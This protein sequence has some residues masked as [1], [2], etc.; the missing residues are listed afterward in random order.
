MESKMSAVPVPYESIKIADE[1]NN[2]DESDGVL[3]RKIY[4]ET[5]ENH[6]KCC[7]DP[8]VNAKLLN[9]NPVLMTVFSGAGTY[10]FLA[11]LFKLWPDIRK[12]ALPYFSIPAVIAGNVGFGIGT[13]SVFYPNELEA[14]A[15]CSCC[16]P[17]CFSHLKRVWMAYLISLGSAFT[18]S[19]GTV[20][21]LDLAI[22]PDDST[23]SDTKFLTEILPFPAAVGLF[24]FTW[25]SISPTRKQQGFFGRY[26]RLLN[27]L[28]SFSKFLLY[29]SVIQALLLPIPISQFLTY[30]LGALGGLGMV[31]AQNIRPQHQEKI[32]MVIIYLANGQLLYFLGNLFFL[33][34]PNNHSAHAHSNPFWFYLKV[35]YFSLAIGA[36]GVITVLRARQYV[37]KVI[38]SEAWVPAGNPEWLR[39]QMREELLPKIFGNKAGIAELKKFLQANPD[40]R[41]SLVDLCA[42]DSD[43]S[44]QLAK[45]VEDKEMHDV[46]LSPRVQPTSSDADLLNLKTEED[47]LSNHS[48]RSTHSDPVTFQYEQKQQSTEPLV[49]S[50]NIPRTPPSRHT[51]S[52]SATSKSWLRRSC[53][54]LL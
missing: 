29:S 26:P 54:V 40:Y 42:N 23:I 4:Q 13:H 8:E 18:F 22:H 50:D 39:Q 16:N 12:T 1:K 2:K 3:Y 28:D 37:K 49:A 20:I 17:N 41:K 5:I 24:C 52:S 36:G 43:I 15:R 27:F 38:R 19:M 11:Q 31:A 14:N 45:I 32:R 47:A 53:C 21:K 7:S 6:L 46:P 44:N 35:A 30:M 51:P 25:E 34:N 10:A 48:S 9:E 33:E